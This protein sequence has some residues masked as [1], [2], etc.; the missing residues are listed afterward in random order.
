MEKRV[1]GRFS[2]VILHQ[3]MRA[4]NILDDQ[5]QLLDGFESFIYEFQRDGQSCIL[6]IGHSLRRPENLIRGEVDWINYLHQG[7]AG[8]SQ[9]ILAENG[10]LVVA[11]E[12]GSGDYFLATAFEKAA[13]GPPGEEILG[14]GFYEDYGRLLGRM[15]SLTKNYL[16][17]DPAW[18][19]PDWDE[20]IMLEVLEWLPESEEFVAE[21]YIDL[22]KYLDQLPKSNDSYG[23]IHFDAHMG[24]MFVDG[25]G[26]ITL[27]DFDDCNYSWFMNDIAIVLF[28]IAMG[29]E[30]QAAFTREFMTHF[31]HGY[32][33]ENQLDKI[34]LKEIPT[35]LKLREIDLYAVIHRSFDVDNIDHPW[36]AMYMENRKQRIE[37]EV[38][39]IDF[40]FFSLAN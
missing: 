31:L 5:I 39:F 12:D 16:P 21:K 3:V 18:K 6:R 28:Y 27:F 17:G 38:P 40:D 7:G 25:Q 1:K 22:K 9:S 4:Y 36:V 20:P 34:W 10:E 24:N 30:D 37:D 32:R 33:E 15:H 14:S 8:V 19:R 26:K 13:G 11:V 35:F 23:L 2:E 29:K